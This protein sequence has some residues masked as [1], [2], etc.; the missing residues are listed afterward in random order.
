M[1]L[2]KRSTHTE[3]GK[4]GKQKRAHRVDRACFCG[5]GCIETNITKKSVPDRDRFPAFPIYLCV[6]L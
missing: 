5:T 2:L 1:E 4:A 6:E 3:V